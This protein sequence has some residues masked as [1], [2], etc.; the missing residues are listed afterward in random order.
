MSR[1]HKLTYISFSLSGRRVYFNYLIQNKLYC[2]K[3]NL[4]LQPTLEKEDRKNVLKHIGMAFLLDI[5]QIVFPRTICLSIPFHTNEVRF[6]KKLFEE[7]SIEKLFIKKYNISHMKSLWV[8]KKD[9]K[10]D[11]LNNFQKSEKLLLCISGGKDSLTMIETFRGK[12]PF[13]LFFLEPST[14]RFRNAAYKPLSKK[15][16]SLKI[17]SNYDTL[18]GEIQKKYN[19][20]LYSRFDTGQLIFLSTLYAN[21]YSHVLLANELSANIPNTTYKKR[22]VNHQYVK[23]NDCI[24]IV[25]RYISEFVISHF[26][27]FSPFSG[28]YDYQIAKKFFHLCKQR[29]LWTSCNNNSSLLRFCG[30]CYKCAFTYI[31]ALQFTDKRYLLH[32]FPYDLLQNVKLCLPLIDP[33]SQKPLDCVGEKKEVWVALSSIYKQSKDVSS[34]AM[35]Y[36]L[37]ILPNIQNQIQGYQHEVTRC[38]TS[39]ELVPEKYQP[40]I[41]TFMR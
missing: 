25:N 10:T 5:A 17:D 23:S 3:L 26:S 33:L 31:I 7:I 16:I 32:F 6:W 24:S 8:Y 34:P 22:Q 30:M 13:D 12:V 14:N 21:T 36:F 18:M 20:R 15:F 37:R 35:K 38:N 11:P 27:A 41:R 2:L 1:T 4:S 29:K 40:I 39:W 9:I 28:Y 19:S